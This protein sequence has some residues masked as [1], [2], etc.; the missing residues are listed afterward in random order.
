MN[1]LFS[2]IVDIVLIVSGIASAAL[3]AYSGIWYGRQKYTLG[4]LAYGAMAAL[5][6]AVTLNHILMM[7]V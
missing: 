5:C 2:K 1:L 6:A 4:A 3:F 7:A